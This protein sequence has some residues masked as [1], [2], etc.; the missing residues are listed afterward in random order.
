MYLNAASVRDLPS[1][2]IDPDKSL[3]CELW[4][5]VQRS[6]P[7]LTGFKFRLDESGGDHLVLIV[8][9]ARAFRFPR[10]GN[11]GS[12]LEIRVLRALAR[13]A[14]IATP[15]YDIVDPDGQFASYFLIAGV[16]LTPAIF[17]ALSAGK[18]RVAIAEAVGLLKALHA[19]NPRAVEPAGVCPRM[20]SA[21]QF[22]DR[23][24]DTRLPAL[25]SR[26][27]E[28]LPSIEA[29]L[30]RYRTDR[31]PRDV[32]LHGDLVSDHLLVDES[33][34]RLTGIIDF[35]DVA[36]GD[37]A[38]DLLGFWIYGEHAA[39]QGRPARTR[40]P[41]RKTEPPHPPGRGRR[42]WDA[43][44]R[45]A[46]CSGRAQGSRHRCGGS[47]RSPARYGPARWPRACPCASP[48]ARRA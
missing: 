3:C 17:S 9:G 25:A 36:L 44:R 2:D 32:V 19:L 28:L 39:V 42:A 48:S 18:A 27:P 10:L 26:A 37:P 46:T 21:G 47:E 35:G 34:G 43:G 14:G 13:H 38:H 15:H 45:R 12:D 30:W 4:Q 6:F 24:R 29:F 5:K 20:W 23:L 1:V 33:T 22:A 7:D 31:A 8:D 11:H 16:P 40:R 41:C